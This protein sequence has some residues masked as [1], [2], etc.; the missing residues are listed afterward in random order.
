MN[1]TPFEQA[2]AALGETPESV[3]EILRAKGIKGYKQ[4]ATY[5]PIANYLVSCGFKRVG[6]ASQANRYPDDQEHADPLETVLLPQGVKRWINQFDDG[7][8]SEFE[9]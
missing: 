4:R 1:M 2:V 6:V 3:R 9:W 8:E 5:C 7:Q